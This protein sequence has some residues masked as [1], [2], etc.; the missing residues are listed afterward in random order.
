ML[1]KRRNI[2]NYSWIWKNQEV[3][4]LLLDDDLKNGEVMDITCVVLVAKMHLKWVMSPVL[5]VYVFVLCT[6]F[7]KR[8]KKGKDFLILFCYG[9]SNLYLRVLWV[10]H[11]IKCFKGGI[12]LKHCRGGGAGVIIRGQLSRG[13]LA[14]KL[15][16]QYK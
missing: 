16:I 15:I 1:S 4:K 14:P 12:I 11:V 6:K 13:L 5:Y 7:I 3:V 8:K 9:Y 2:H 10:L